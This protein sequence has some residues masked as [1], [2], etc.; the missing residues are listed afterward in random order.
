MVKS[1]DY[2]HYMRMALALAAEA[3]RAGEIPVG[4]VV[5]DGTGAVVGRG[6][7]RREETRCVTGHAELEALEAACRARGD[8]RLA[9]CTV[10][11]T[12]EPCPMCAGALLN[13]RLGALVYGAR[14]P[15]TGSAGSVLNLF[16]EGYPARTAVTGG[17]LREESEE[18]LREFFEARRSAPFRRREL[19]PPG[20]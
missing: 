20:D 3:A 2:E 17:V 13:A 6:R 19:S 1:Q 7:N 16:A 8:W 10:F 4:C 9:D 14:E 5:A 11:V 12:L 18:L 15:V